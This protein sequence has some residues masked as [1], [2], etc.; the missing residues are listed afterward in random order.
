[1]K[2]MKVNLDSIFKIIICFIH[3]SNQNKNKWIVSLADKQ[4]SRIIQMKALKQLQ[5]DQVM[6]K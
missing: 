2:P 3:I 6:L 4:K 5:E 1:M